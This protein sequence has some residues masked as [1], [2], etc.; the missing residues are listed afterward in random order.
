MLKDAERATFA[1]G[2]VT[3]KRSKTQSALDS[4][5]VLKL[6]PEMINGFHKTKQGH[7]VFRSIAMMIV[8]TMHLYR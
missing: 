3:W 8:K 7:D 6:H 4:K 1:N 2:S 5:A